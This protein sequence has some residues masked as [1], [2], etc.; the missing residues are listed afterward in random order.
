MAFKREEEK[1]GI[2]LPGLI[3]IVFLLLIFSLVTLTVSQSL[4]DNAGEHDKDAEFKLP[5]IESAAARKVENELTTLLFQI[6]HLVEND[7]ASP[8]VVFA[9]NPDRPNSQTVKTARETAGADSTRFRQFPADFLSLSDAA[10]SRL[11]ACR[12][13]REEIRRYKEAHFLGPDPTHAIEIRAV[14]DTEFRIINHILEY[15]STFNDTI[16][17]FMVRTISGKEVSLGL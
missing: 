8:K 10:F 17:R 4:V 5:E 12:F 7:A 9:L 15:T 13:I 16:P 11:A 2:S 3:D 1:K 14:R 6:E